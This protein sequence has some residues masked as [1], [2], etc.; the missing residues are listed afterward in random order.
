MTSTERKIC[1]LCKELRVWPDDFRKQQGKPCPDCKECHRKKNAVY[2]TRPDVIASQKDRG[3]RKRLA[4][5][6]NMTPEAYDIMVEAQNHCCALC[7][8]GGKARLLVDQSGFTKRVRGLV[9][10]SCKKEISKLEKYG[11]AHVKEIS[12][13]TNPHIAFKGNYILSQ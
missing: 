5:S 3:R 6:Y 13:S 11:K 1:R 10:D 2:R 12:K 9:C 7:G 8:Q 4:D